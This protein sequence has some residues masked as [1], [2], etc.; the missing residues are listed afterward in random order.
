MHPSSSLLAVGYGCP[1]VGMHV[2][3]GHVPVAALPQPARTATDFA[4]PL[5]CILGRGLCCMDPD[6]DVRRHR[7]VNPE[8]CKFLLHLPQREGCTG[9]RHHQPGDLIEILFEKAVPAR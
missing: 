8:P 2:T 7:R 4:C 5:G 9:M 6:A 1:T 3:S